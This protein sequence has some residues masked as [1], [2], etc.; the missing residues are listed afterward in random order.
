MSLAEALNTT[1]IPRVAGLTGA[2]MTQVTKRPDRGSL[3]SS[4]A[5]RIGNGSYD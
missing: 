2:R 3:C 5:M 1:R 4:I